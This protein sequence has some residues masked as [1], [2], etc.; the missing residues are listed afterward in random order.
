MEVIEKGKEIKTRWAIGLLQRPL[1]QALASVKYN[2]VK[3]QDFAQKEAL[4]KLSYAPVT[5]FGD[6]MIME[7]Q[8]ALPLGFTYDSQISQEEFN[9]LSKTQKDMAIF[10]ACVSGDNLPGIDKISAEE[11][12]KRLK[13]FTLKD[14]ARLVA[15]KRHTAMKMTNFTQKHFTGEISMDKKSLLFLSIPFDKG[16][17][18]F[19]NGQPVQTVQTNIGFT[20]ILLDKGVHH[21]ELKYLPPYLKPALSMSLLFLILYLG[22]GFLR[23]KR[24]KNS[25][26]PNTFNLNHHH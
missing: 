9:E 24:P 20:G 3:P 18:A 1:L 12:Q 21:I 13:N 16:W 17:K 14:F 11:M 26:S 22:I 7:H 2:L 23:I 6:V 19:D 4:Y 8:F 15:Q 25:V 5:R 10:I